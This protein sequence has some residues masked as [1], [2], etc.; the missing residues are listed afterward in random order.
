MFPLLQ[1]SQWNQLLLKYQSKKNSRNQFLY[2]YQ[3]SEIT[4]SLIIYKQEKSIQTHTHK[5]AISMGWCSSSDWQDFSDSLRRSLKNFR[6]RSR[7]PILGNIIFIV[8]SSMR[9]K[10]W[11]SIPSPTSLK[12]LTFKSR[13]SC[14]KLYLNYDYIW[15]YEN[16][17][18]KNNNNI[19][20]K[21]FDL[22]TTT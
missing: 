11:S 18:I 12:V 17:I 8:S 20:I 3:H 19:R 6:K 4:N 13:T 9:S 14:G 10:L 2:Q 5:V 22:S 21:S 16:K 7:G 15:S 1:K